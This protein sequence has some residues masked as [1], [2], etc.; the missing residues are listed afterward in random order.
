MFNS[1]VN[2]TPLDVLA[3]SDRSTGE[4]KNLLQD[5]GW[6]RNPRRRHILP[7]VDQ[8]E[9]SRTGPISDLTRRIIT[10]QGFN[11]LTSTL[12]FLPNTIWLST[13]PVPR[14]MQIPQGPCPLPIHNRKFFP[15]ALP[16]R[17]RTWPITGVPFGV[18]GRKHNPLETI[19]KSVPIPFVLVEPRSHRSLATLVS[20]STESEDGT[21]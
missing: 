17:R 3:A 8:R 18:V 6:T 20:R 13:I 11:L 10:S 21:E 7:A 16:L 5:V 9:T 2:G 12:V 14:L 15:Y 4:P 19:S 1:P